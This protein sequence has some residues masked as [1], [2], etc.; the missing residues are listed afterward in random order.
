MLDGEIMILIEELL[1]NKCT[2]CLEHNINNGTCI[3]INWRDEKNKG[4]WPKPYQ[5]FGI[6]IE[7]I[8]GIV[9]GQDPTIEKARSIEW[10]LEA[11]VTD[12]N[13]GKFLREVFSMIPNLRFDELYFTNLVKCRFK[14]KPGKGDR[15]ISNFLRDMARQCYLRYL[16]QEIEIC[17]HAQYIFTLGRDVFNLLAELLEV[18]HQTLELFKEY[19]GTKLVI[20]ISKVGRKCYLI[21]IPHQPTYDLANRYLPYSKDEVR[22]KLQQLYS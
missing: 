20:P 17:R 11:N 2:Y 10:I 3:D 7:S 1:S 8:Q 5:E 18:E 22:K 4:F 12:S 19:Y 15:N 9:I 13:L 6:N 16:N 14:E 21:P